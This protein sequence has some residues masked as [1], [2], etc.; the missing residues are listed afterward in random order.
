MESFQ[1]KLTIRTGF[2]FQGHICLDLYKFAPENVIFV[3]FWWIN[4][5]K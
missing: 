3:Q 1:K 4:S 2:V 5:F